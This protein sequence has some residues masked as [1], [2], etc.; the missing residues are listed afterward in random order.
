MPSLLATYA[1]SVSGQLSD[2]KKRI[3]AR[4]DLPGS[5]IDG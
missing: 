1:R 4:G 3:E 2:L 5:P